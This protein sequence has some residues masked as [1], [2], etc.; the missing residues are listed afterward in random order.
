MQTQIMWLQQDVQTAHYSSFIPAGALYLVLDVT[1]RIHLAG[2]I[3]AN[4]L[5]ITHPRPYACADMVESYRTVAN[6]LWC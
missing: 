4:L 1:H 5:S 2:S 3:P 6:S